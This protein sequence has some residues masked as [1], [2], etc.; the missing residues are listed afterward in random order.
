LT[1]AEPE[2][3]VSDRPD[4]QHVDVR[5][6]AG[7]ARIALTAEEQREFQGQLDDILDYVG[8][9]TELDVTGIDPTAHAVPMANIL[10]DDV[11]RPS[12]DRDHMVQNAPASVDDAY[13]RVPA[14][15]GEEH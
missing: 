12:M 9:L 11:A 15:I 2:V 3:N 4:L 8:K 6:V 13:V 7:L 5:Y 1:G 10:R 14:V